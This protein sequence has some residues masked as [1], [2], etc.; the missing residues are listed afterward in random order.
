MSADFVT[1]GDKV[2]KGQTIGTIGESASFEVAQTPHLHFE[3]YKD[4]KSI[5]P[6][7]ILK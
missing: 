6:T 2:E 3:V 1:I 5:N 7:T 4:G